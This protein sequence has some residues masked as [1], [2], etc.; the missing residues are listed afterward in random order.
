MDIKKGL[1][2]AFRKL[3][4]KVTLDKESIKEFLKEVQ[5][6]LISADVP[7]KLVFELTKKI[8]NSVFEDKIPPAISL[9][10]YVLKKTYDEL[11]QLL[12]GEKPTIE[13]KKKKILLL[14]LYG[15]GKTTSAAKLAYFYKNRGL[16]VGLLC[17]DIDRPAAYEQLEQLA[18][19]V[20]ASFYGIKNEKNLE[21]ILELE[22]QVKE[23]VL[24]IDSA[25]RNAFDQEMAE[26]IKRIEQKIKP[27]EKILV[28]SA[29]IGQI[30]GQ[31]AKQFDQVLKIT[32]IFI[33]K[34]DGSG[35]GGGAIAACHQTKV[36]IMFIGTGEKID[37]IEAFD[38][39]K[40]VGNLLGFPDFESLI[41]KIK[42]AAEKEELKM[43][44][45]ESLD[46]ETFYKQLKAAKNLG[47]LSNVLGML[48]LSEVPA[49]LVQLSE[50]KLK[51]YEV[52]INSMTKKERK[53]PKLLKES[54]RIE[55]IAK[56]S[57]LKVEE[58]REFIA[59][60]NKMEKLF[61]GIKKNRGLQK[62]LEKV[63]GSKKINEI[64][65]N[66]KPN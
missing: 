41:E 42:Q 9:K 43:E 58:V 62:R 47:P 10:E 12:G 45:F 24:I 2:E 3:S 29:D 20:G 61:S 22:N 57:G 21:K 50:Q 54:G 53:N 13:L 37:Q 49:D 55:R 52:I 36:P 40:F 31:Q 4:A 18:K 32:A 59:Q 25:G 44:D 48:G 11:C 19:K 66:F 51:K 1:K 5:I 39:K 30:A 6:A 38:S 46:F 33:T 27:D 15:S 60:F 26:Q 8:E 14:G 16:S 23:D 63:L 17:A 65:D 56:G 28:V 64:L 35:K 7:V 34:L